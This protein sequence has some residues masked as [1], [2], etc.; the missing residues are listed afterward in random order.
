[1]S[2]SL[3]TLEPQARTS[4]QPTSDTHDVASHILRE[5]R[6][7]LSTLLPD[8]L[9]TIKQGVVV[10]D[11]ED[12][13]VYAN[14]RYGEIY[15]LG[16]AD[17]AKGSEAPRIRE[18]QARRLSRDAKRVNAYLSMCAREQRAPYAGV[19]LLPDGRSVSVTRRALADGS[20]VA[21]HED[22]TDRVG[23]EHRIAHA[24]R[25]DA[26]TGLPN[27]AYFLEQLETALKRVR[28]GDRIALLM[29]DL[30]RFKTVNDTHGHAVGD[31]LIKEV[32]DKLSAAV[33]DADVVARLGG[34]EFA[35][36]QIPA[37][38]P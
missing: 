38:T 28:R 15:Q 24:A 26:L 17:L 32:A 2:T 23:V 33:R 6:P 14:R 5:V 3:T 7:Q 12:R 11:A 37:P 30:D 27:R 1:M 19:R 16:E 34:D 4:T 18:A 10:F 31:L 36:L 29:L 35:I 8:A 21:T 22:V 9:D 13:L 20:V 25:H